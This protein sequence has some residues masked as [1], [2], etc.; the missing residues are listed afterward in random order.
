[1]IQIECEFGIGHQ[2]PTSW[3]SSTGS[4]WSRKVI[5]DPSTSLIG[6]CPPRA[7]IALAPRSAPQVVGIGELDAGPACGAHDVGIQVAPD[8]HVRSQRAL[9]LS[10][11]VRGASVIPYPLVPM[12]AARSKNGRLPPRQVVQVSR[13]R[14]L[15]QLGKLLGLEAMQHRRA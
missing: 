1:M 10:M 9:A 3:S 6:P 13:E 8:A 12:H 7:G 4:P 11:K 14:I 2:T 15:A 5:F